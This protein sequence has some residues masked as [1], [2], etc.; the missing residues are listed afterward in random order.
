M[1]GWHAEAHPQDKKAKKRKE[2]RHA[3]RA[4]KR[5]AVADVSRAGGD[6]GDTSDDQS[7]SQAAAVGQL[8]LGSMPAVAPAA[9]AA[10]EAVLAVGD[11]GDAAAQDAQAHA[12]TTSTRASWLRRLDSDI[13]GAACEPELAAHP[14]L[15]AAQVSSSKKKKKKEE[16]KEKKKKKENKKKEKKKKKKDKKK[17]KKEE[18]KK[19]ENSSQVWPFSISMFQCGS[20]AL[21]RYSMMHLHK[22]L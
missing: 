5:R 16:K 1:L 9:E 22:S 3:S 15:S 11:S 4:C 12:R 7:H 21:Q 10:G 8:L 14:H 20:M 19:K 17:K 6:A 18:K 2:T 13:P